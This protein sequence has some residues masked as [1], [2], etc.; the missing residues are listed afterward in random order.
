MAPADSSHQAESDGQSFGT[1]ELQ[2]VAGDKFTAFAL[3]NGISSNSPP[4]KP[5]FEPVFSSA[6][7]RHQQH[8]REQRMRKTMSYCSP[9]TDTGKCQNEGFGERC[10]RPKSH[11][12]KVRRTEWLSLFSSGENGEFGE[13]AC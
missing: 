4:F 5:V 12:V 6:V 2:L 1:G 7:L 11:S 9:Q 13:N 3:S 10:E 8:R